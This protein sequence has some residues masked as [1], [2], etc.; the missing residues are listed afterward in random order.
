MENLKRLRKAKGL[1][2]KELGEMCDVSESMIGLIENGNRKP[3]YE[4]LL[5]LGEAL[6]CN[7]DDLMRGEKNPALDEEDGL[8]E[9]QRYLLKL[10]PDLSSLDATV[11]ASVAKSLVDAHKSQGGS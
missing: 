8:T 10:I 1:T 11:L 7:V 6:D 3:S 4:L 5:K 2:Q 9:A